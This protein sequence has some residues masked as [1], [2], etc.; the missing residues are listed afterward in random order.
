[1]EYARKTKDTSFG[2]YKKKEA[3][4]PRRNDYQRTAEN[5]KNESQ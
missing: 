1:M 2:Q 5:A 4:K 3:E